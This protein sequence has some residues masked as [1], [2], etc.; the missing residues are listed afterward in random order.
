MVEELE[1]R[2]FPCFHEIIRDMTA[3]AKKQETK[4]KMITNPLVFV[5]DPLGFNKKLIYGRAAHY[6]QSFGVGNDLCFFDRGM[7]DV[8]A[9]MD[10]FDQV[11]PEDFI[12]LSEQ[13]RYDNVFILPPWKEIY[14]SD[15]ERLESFKEA[16]ELHEHLMNTYKKFEYTPILVPKTTVAKRVQFILETLS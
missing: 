12:G 13:K 7:P 10:Y 11:Y 8:L 14:S 16:E 4:H 15:N 5:D 3:Q 9:Y 6:D 1:K 2:G